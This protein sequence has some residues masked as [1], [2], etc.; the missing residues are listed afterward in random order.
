M[1]MGTADKVPE[2]PPVATVFAEDLPEAER[3]AA[4]T[5]NPGGLSNL[6]NTCYLNSTLQCLRVIPE[7]S[8]SLQKCAPPAPL[9]PHHN[10]PTH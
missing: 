5:N 10:P 1:L 9:R 2:P 6:G 3:N 4:A 8:T 7:V